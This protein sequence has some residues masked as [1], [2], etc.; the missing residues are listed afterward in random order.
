MVSHILF[1]NC[2][3]CVVID[4]LVRSSMKSATKCIMQC[5]LCDAGNLQPHQRVLCS[6]I[7]P[8]VCRFQCIFS[9]IIQA[10]RLE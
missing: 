8:S 2:L 6:R 10:E 9:S 7:V 4:V 1:S 3:K 5:D